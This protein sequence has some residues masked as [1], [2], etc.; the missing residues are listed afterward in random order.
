MKNKPEDILWSLEMIKKTANTPN[1][2]TIKHT[3]GFIFDGQIDDLI[4]LISDCIRMKEEY[5]SQSGDSEPSEKE[6]RKQQIFNEYWGGKK[7]KK[8]E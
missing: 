4:E 3:G 5:K 2:C 1:G 7:K 8:N 6:V